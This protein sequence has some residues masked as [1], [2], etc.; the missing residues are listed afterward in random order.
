MA[1]TSSTAE[2]LEGWLTAKPFWEQYIWK[3]CLEK[4]S[5]TAKDLEQCYAYLCE[6]L[7]LICARRSMATRVSG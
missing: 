6:H 5:L 1:D 3:I 7:E 2:S 4:D